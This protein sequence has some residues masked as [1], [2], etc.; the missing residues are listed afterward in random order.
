MS[1]VSFE[2]LSSESSELNWSQWIGYLRHDFWNDYGDPRSAHLP[3][4]GGGPWKVMA[5]VSIYLLFTKHFGPKL[6][7]TRKPFQ[8]RKAMITHNAILAIGNGIGFIIGM[9]V[10]GFGSSSFSCEAARSKSGEITSFKEKAYLY[11]GWLYFFSKF[12]DFIDTVFFV[13][14][15]KDN[16]IS[17]LHVFH[18]SFMPIASYVGLKFIPGGNI[19]LIAL[20]N[21]MIHT[22][23]YTYYALSAAGPEY[24]K[25]LWW[26]QYLT[27]AQVLQFILFMGHSVYG[28]LTPGCSY[29][30]FFH[31]LEL[32]YAIL[33]FSMFFTFY[34]KAY[35]GKGTTK[36][37]KSNSMA[38]SAGNELNNN[39]KGIPIKD[40]SN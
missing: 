37:T 17:G 31:G 5:L 25:Y 1:E 15:K 36:A 29:H 4:L 32:V 27:L 40:K 18:H 34:R 21:T 26:K 33:F 9:Y 20:V 24:Q 38:D 2:K 12:I 10:T 35:P 16:H 7:E 8:L 28:L 6:M 19:V 30:P 13:L 14:R 11:G 23:M 22:I 39:A 3:L